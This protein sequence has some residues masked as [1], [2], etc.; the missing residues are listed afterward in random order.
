[1]VPAVIAIDTAGV[2]TGFTVIV[3]PALLA[4]IGLAQG[5]LDVIT[6]VIISPLANAAFV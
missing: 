2:N 4:V 6:Q 3:M 1:L 5:E